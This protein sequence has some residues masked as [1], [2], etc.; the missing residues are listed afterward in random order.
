MSGYLGVRKWRVRLNPKHSTVNSQHLRCRDSC[1][2]N[3]RFNVVESVPYCNEQKS[4]EGLQTAWS[5]KPRVW[6]DSFMNGVGYR[7]PILSGN[8]RDVGLFQADSDRLREKILWTYIYC[9]NWSH[10][11]VFH[12]IIQ[13]I[14]QWK[15]NEFIV[16]Y[17]C[18]DIF[19]L[20]ESSSGQ[21]LNC[22]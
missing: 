15:H 16:S 20:V 6:A 7:R 4:S 17:K 14:F 12:L 21:S 11:D 2:L 1:G 19:R 9:F 3:P 22:M 10:L 13:H 5:S 18:G 8:I